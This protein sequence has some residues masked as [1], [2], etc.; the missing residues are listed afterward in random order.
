MFVIS[1]E[2]F[3]LMTRIRRKGGNCVGGL[4]IAV[5]GPVVGAGDGGVVDMAA[6]NCGTT[7]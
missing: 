5:L 3:G 7:V 6:T 1:R 2:L 4:G